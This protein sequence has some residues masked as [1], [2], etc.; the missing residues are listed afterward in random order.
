MDTVVQLFSHEYAGEREENSE[1]AV[2]VGST[3]L[4]DVFVVVSVHFASALIGVVISVIA[5]S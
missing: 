3:S 2:K 5:L 1:T 4:Q